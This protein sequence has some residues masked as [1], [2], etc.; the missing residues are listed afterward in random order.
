MKVTGLILEKN[1]RRRIQD[2]NVDLFLTVIDGDN[3][4]IE[5]GKS[6]QDGRFEIDLKAGNFL[7][8]GT[9]ELKVYDPESHSEGYRTFEVKAANTKDISIDVEVEIHAIDNIKGKRFIGILIGLLLGV[10][11][12]WLISHRTWPEVHT[13]DRLASLVSLAKTQLKTDSIHRAE[14]ARLIADT[15]RVDSIIV[16]DDSA[17]IRSR[18]VLS[19]MF[20][21]A[22]K[23]ELKCSTGNDS[24]QCRTPL[25]L[26]I[27]NSLIGQITK[28]KS[29]SEK[30]NILNSLDT[31]ISELKPKVS[32]WVNGFWKFFE[33][34]FWALIA[35]LIRLI[36]NNTRYVYRRKFRVHVIPRQIGFLICIPILA[37]F[38]AMFLS[39]INF[40]IAV[41]ES[42]LVL[43]MTQ[44][45]LI[46]LI[47][48]LV[49]F[50]PWRASD[51]MKD[52]ADRFFEIIT[53]WF[54]KPKKSNDSTDPPKAKP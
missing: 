43:D 49:G 8:E 32:L 19:T 26:E 3:K 15:S 16:T 31:H 20:D 54:N 14:N 46:V 7:A 28:A 41:G 17:F 36:F 35:T 44:G 38:I 23:K 9:Y 34:L 24:L 52:F 42:K 45:Y 18:D 39:L 6:D 11:I 51:F 53:G 10:L 25:N 22:Y 4:L 48:A 1:C 2:V 50:A 33:I 13:S 5:E 47:A 27:I 30:K 37:I 21:K 29:Y 40:S 12:L